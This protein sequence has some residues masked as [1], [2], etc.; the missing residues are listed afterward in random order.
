MAT[1]RWAAAW[2][3]VI[4]LAGLTVAGPGSAAEIGPSLAERAGQEE[5][6]RS[7]AV[8]H[9]TTAHG[10]G[11]LARNLSPPPADLTLL[12]RKNGG[13]FPFDGVTA[14]VDGREEVAGHGPSDM[15]V[16]GE[17]F[18]FT[19]AGVSEPGGEY[20]VLGRISAVVAYLRSIQAN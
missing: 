14:M 11:P 19:E 7:C 18:G 1:G 16:W 2:A 9:G 4:V 3:S 5:F 8:C 17:R 10:N 12:S 13:T 6:R 20:V 15:P